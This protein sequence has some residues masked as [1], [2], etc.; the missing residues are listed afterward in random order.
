MTLTN[1][2]K[3][4]SFLPYYPPLFGILIYSKWDNVHEEVEFCEAG[5]LKKL[6]KNTYNFLYNVTDKHR[7]WSP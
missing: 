1:P 7:G 2:E 3:S 6:E 5:L 4:Y